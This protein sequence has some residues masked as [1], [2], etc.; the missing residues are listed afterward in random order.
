MGPGGYL[1]AG[2]M[3][4]QAMIRGG[5]ALLGLVVSSAAFAAGAL[6]A[7]PAAPAA[8][9]TAVAVPAVVTSSTLPALPAVPAALNA[10]PGQATPARAALP[11][12]DGLGSG[13]NLRPIRGPGNINIPLPP[14]F[15]G[16]SGASAA[17]RS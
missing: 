10:A 15:D 7:L 6:P 4:H 1:E 5:S 8:G 13:T 16:H 9:Q 3:K 14:L 2:D 17:R 12:L 11:G